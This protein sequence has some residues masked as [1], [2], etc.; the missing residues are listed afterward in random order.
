ISY[1]REVK[2]LSQ[3]RDSVSYDI[4]LTFKNTKQKPMKYEYKE[5]I[6][7][8]KTVITPKGYNSSKIKIIPEGF[9]IDEDDPLQEN[10]QERIYEYEVLF[11]YRDPNKDDE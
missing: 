2:V 3:K 10:G 1:N 7:D 6:S 11:E 9:K 4:K 5:I 8:V